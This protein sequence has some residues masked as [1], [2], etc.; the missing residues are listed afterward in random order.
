MRM[1]GW[2]WLL[3]NVLPRSLANWLPEIGSTY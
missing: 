3:G 1:T 2:Y